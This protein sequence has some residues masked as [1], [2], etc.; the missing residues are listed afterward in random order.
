MPSPKGKF[1]VYEERITQH[2][3]E[4]NERRTRPITWKYFQWLTLLFV[5]IY[6]DRYFMTGRAL[7]DLN[8]YIDRFNAK[9]PEWKDIAPY[10][11]DDLNKLCLQNATGSGKTL[12]MHMNLKL[13]DSMRGRRVKKVTCP[14]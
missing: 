9:W 11:I 6:L 10:T 12:L 13:F 8:A 3:R 2:T 5:E 4:I 7:S 14:G 1:F